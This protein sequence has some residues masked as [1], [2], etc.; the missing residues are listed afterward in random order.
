MREYN[1][2]KIKWNHLLLGP[3]TAL[4][5]ILVI[6]IVTV[7]YL[8]TMLPGMGYSGDTAKF[9]FIGKVLGVPHPPG[10]PL[11]V[12]LNRL[13]VTLPIGSIA[14][15]ANLMS[16]FFGLLTVVFL[17]FIILRLGVDSYLA[18][19]TSLTFAFSYTFWTQSLIAEVYTLNSFFLAVI[20]FLLL[21]WQQTGRRVYFQ[22]SVLLF[23]LSLAHHLTM[24]FLAPA[25]L[26]LL[27]KLVPRE[28]FNPKTWRLALI[29]LTLAIIPYSFL[30]VRTYQR[31]PY[32][33]SP[34]RNLVDFYNVITA[35]YFQVDLFAF[36]WREL[37]T[38]RIPWFFDQIEDEWT[39]PLLLI[40]II[41]WGWMNRSHRIFS[42]FLIIFMVAQSIFITN[43]HI[44]DIF[45]F[46]IPVYFCL[47]IFLGAGWQSLISKFKTLSLIPRFPALKLLSLAIFSLCI[48]SPLYLGYKN[49]PRAD[50]KKLTFYD[51]Q[52]N[53]LFTSIDPKKPV[54]ILTDNYLETQFVYNKRFLDYPQHFILHVAYEPD[55]EVLPQIKTR[56]DYEILTNRRLQCYLFPDCE[57]L[58]PEA[59]LNQFW[60]QRMLPERREILSAVYFNS[61]YVRLKLFKEGIRTVKLI[62]REKKKGRIHFYYRAFLPAKF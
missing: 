56:L 50:F 7:I 53:V 36:G 57:R 5:L 3:K 1:Q 8:R 46:F 34:V 55:R 54:I 15:R 28:L 41:G 38:K 19:G 21:K 10:Y 32:L 9:Q 14:F 62:G 27:I 33:E 29:S 43:Y 48:A 35:K 37:I 11:Y 45:V 16:L 49:F 24:V 47:A 51:E 61:T 25:L 26:F 42:F 13:F 12:L 39:W 30:V 52:F 22:W 17:Y 4:A 60:S 2:N 40:M 58:R 44:H 20:I 18:A 59:M 31:A 23:G 6:I